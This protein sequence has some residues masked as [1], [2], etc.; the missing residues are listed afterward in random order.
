MN[1]R[2]LLAAVTFA[3]L[4]CAPQAPRAAPSTL[5]GQSWDSI[6]T[7]PDWS[8][9]WTPIPPPQGAPSL[10]SPGGIFGTTAPLKPELA[11]Y[12]DKRVKS[13]AGEGDQGVNGIPL[14]N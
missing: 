4:V 7:L 9:M 13:V 5:R 1:S 6:K 8:G 11:A 14:S 10:G 12:R 2:V 3:L